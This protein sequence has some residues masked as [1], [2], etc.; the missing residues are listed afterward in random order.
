MTTNDHERAVQAWLEEATDSRMSGLQTSD[1]H[2]VYQIGGDT[3][4][5]GVALMRAQSQQL[6]EA[7]A[8]CEKLAKAAKKAN[9]LTTQ[10]LMLHSRAHPEVVAV[11]R[12]ADDALRAALPPSTAK[13]RP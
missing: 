13:E 2:G 1:G 11:W 4:K 3:L 5:R 7:R 10:W 6:A 12:E 8:Q 9:A